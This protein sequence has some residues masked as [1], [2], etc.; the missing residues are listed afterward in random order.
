MTRSLL[1]RLQSTT[2]NG[3]SAPSKFALRCCSRRA[4]TEK[5]RCTIR[6]ATGIERMSAKKTQRET[7]G[8]GTQVILKHWQEAVPNDRLAHL[9][10]D[11]SR[12]LV[13]ALHTR[14]T[15]HGVSFGHW[16]FLRI[17]WE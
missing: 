7:N 5:S 2:A 4:T 15:Q 17:L 9:V 10:R 14:L 8:D 13:R 11:T 12:A 6:S 1:E 3:R 16:A